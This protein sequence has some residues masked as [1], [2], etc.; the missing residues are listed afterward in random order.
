MKKTMARLTK[1]VD[2]LK[3]ERLDA[4]ELNA[5][6]QKKAR[7]TRERFVLDIAEVLSDSRNIASLRTK[8]KQLQRKVHVAEGLENELRE[9]RKKIRDLEKA[10]RY[11][12]SGQIVEESP[13]PVVPKKQVKFLV[14]AEDKLLLLMF[15]FLETKDVIYSAQVAMRAS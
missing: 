6:I 3:T 4:V 15:S 11:R 5:K 2:K 7:D 14:H 12:E 9:A 1:T 10:E 13:L 8:I